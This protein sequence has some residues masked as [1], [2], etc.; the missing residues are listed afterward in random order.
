MLRR[1]VKSYESSSSQG[2]NSFFKRCSAQEIQDLGS[3]SKVSSPGL[4][5]GKGGKDWKSG[6]RI[7]GE[8][9]AKL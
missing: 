3:D 9:I 1:S 7:S 8:A 2:K 6:D 5:S 4:R